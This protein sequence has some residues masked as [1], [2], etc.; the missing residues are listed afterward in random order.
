MYYYIDS[1]TGAVYRMWSYYGLGNIS[2][3]L[4]LD[5]LN[6]A[7]NENRIIDCPRPYPVGVVSCLYNEIAG[8][9]CPSKFICIMTIRIN[10]LDDLTLFCY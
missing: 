1:I 4:L 3:P 6:C 10:V 7:G 2:T 5:G 8:I 9:V